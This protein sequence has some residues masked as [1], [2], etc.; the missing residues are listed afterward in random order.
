MP[1]RMEFDSSKSLQVDLLDNFHYICKV[2]VFEREMLQM[3]QEP[4]EAVES[5]F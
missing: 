2:L 1:Y 3:A 4:T 5:D